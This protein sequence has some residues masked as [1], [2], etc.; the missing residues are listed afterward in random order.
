[1]PDYDTKGFNPPAPVAYVDLIHPDTGA[2]W[3]RVPMLLD[4]G[5]D[6]TVVPASVADRLG[7][8][9][10]GAPEYEL[11]AYDGTIRPA[12]AVRLKL[13]FLDRTFNG[14]FLL[15]EQGPGVIGRNVLNAISI[16][17]DGPQ[18]KW[19]EATAA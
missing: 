16:V 15:V 1:M 19:S 14:Q 5:A 6:V 7:I 4:S 9:L 13:V 17:L 3:S 12:P 10:A 8:S 11:M 18:L 2:R